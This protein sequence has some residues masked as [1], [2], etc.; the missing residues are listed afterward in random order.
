MVR[1]NPTLDIDADNAVIPD[2][3]EAQT[4]AGYVAPK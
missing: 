3:V 4:T 2:N 1:V